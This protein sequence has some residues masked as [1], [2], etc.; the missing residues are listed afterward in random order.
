MGVRTAHKRTQSQPCRLY[1]RI[2]ESISKGR[3][4]GIYEPIATGRLDWC[5]SLHPK[6]YALVGNVSRQI[7][8]IHE[9]WFL[10]K[11]MCNIWSGDY[12]FISLLVFD[13]RVDFVV[14]HNS[15]TL[16]H[17][18]LL[19]SSHCNISDPRWKSFCFLIYDIVDRLWSLLPLISPSTMF[20]WSTCLK[21]YSIIIFPVSF[22]SLNTFVLTK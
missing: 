4:K 13:P 11:K 3:R 15:S 9:N 21:T 20:F 12:S 2:F 5:W 18:S 14:F 17:H 7:N 10:K 1:S 8:G 19:S 16:L 6:Y 22:T